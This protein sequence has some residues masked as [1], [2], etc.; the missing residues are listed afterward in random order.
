MCLE[1]I[2]PSAEYRDSWEAAQFEFD[3]EGAFKLQEIGNEWIRESPAVLY[4][5]EEQC[6][7]SSKWI[8]TK[9][10][11][12]VREKRFLGQVDIRPQLTKELAAFGG[13][14]GY[15]IRPSAR[16]QGFGK[17]LL[18]LALDK[19]GELGLEK[20]LVTCDENNMASKK[21]IVTS[22][23]RLYD[24]LYDAVREVTILRYWIIL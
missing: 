4:A 23:G 1:L 11:W 10:Y 14:V 19:A 15:V 9:T 8:P 3:V 2:L 6:H 13:Q 5:S 24:K 21:I 16:L 20:V 18:S 12:L 22:G 7:F 17:K